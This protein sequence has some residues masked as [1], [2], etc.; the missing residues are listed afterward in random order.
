MMAR[1]AFL[2]DTT[3]CT[4]CNTCT[5]KC[6]QEY[7]T[8]QLAARGLFRR[9]VLINDVG[10]L[11]HVCMHCN[12]PSC[13]WACPT[14]ALQKTEVGAV[15][16][17]SSKCIGCKSCVLACPFHVPQWDEQARTIFKCTMCIHRLAEGRQ[18][19]CVEACPTGA[20]DFGDYDAIL[21]KARRE[22][23]ER[24][25]HIYGMEEA[26]GTSVFILTR[27]SPAEIGYPQVPKMLVR[28]G[29]V[30]TLSV[31]LGA[32]LVGLYALK[33][34]RERAQGETKESET[35]ES[36]TMEKTG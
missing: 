9:L 11:H 30:S 8:H 22:A 27:K 12:D 18:P 33:K 25:L 23:S 35:K 17:D 15:V 14:G 24:H 4:G 19:A 10:I 7:Q 16:Y 13:V 21:Q 6:I 20:L 34:F 26:G 31:G 3:F 36:E 1:K 32:A 2:I 29:T 28:L 5:Y